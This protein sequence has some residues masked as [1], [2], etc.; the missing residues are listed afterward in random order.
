ML[1]LISILLGVCDINCEPQQ[2]VAS[3]NVE[4]NDLQNK[5]R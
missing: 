5:A 4:F 2:P 3:A 1:L